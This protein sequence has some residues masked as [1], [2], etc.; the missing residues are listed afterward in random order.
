MDRQHHNAILQLTKK[1]F[2]LLVQRHPESKEPPD[3]LIQKPTR[4]IHAVTHDLL[5]EVIHKKFSVSKIFSI[6]GTNSFKF[7]QSPQKIKPRQFT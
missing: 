6:I 5:L 7:H 2:E 4:P 1:T 3:I